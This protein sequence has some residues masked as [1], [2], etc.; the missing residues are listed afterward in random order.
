MSLFGVQGIPFS[1]RSAGLQTEFGTWAPPGSRV[2]YVSS[3]SRDDIR[4]IKS[5]TVT[6]LAAALSQCRSGYG[7]VVICLPGH[8]ES[9]TTGDLANLVA[10]TRIIGYGRGSNMPTFR[11]TATTSTWP[12]SVADV[13]LAG[14]RLRLE[15][16]NGVTKA[17][18]VTGADVEIRDCDIEVASGATAKA[19]I[20]I[21]VG[22]GAARFRLASCRLR[23]T[24]THNV[25]DGV[26]VV[27][28]VDGVVIENCTM[29]FSATAANGLIHVTAAAT[30]LTFRDLDLYNTHTSSTA[31]ITLD[32]TACDGHAIRVYSA[33]KT[34][35]T[36]TAEGITFGTAAL[37]QCNQ[38][39]TV[40]N[41][42]AN[43]ILSPAVET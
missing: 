43:G 5:K 11:W 3:V 38:C 25:T 9:V 32:D 41:G 16:A 12:I 24:A 36:A 28:A 42:Q 15:G 37:V 18:N 8:S 35:G 21:E 20:A 23:G 22:T 40:D 34:D 30:N 17:I 2:V 1:R 7:D 39:Y 29:Q 14:L 6:T 33:V 31:T 27:A 10:G 19:T 4:E 13:S 26:K